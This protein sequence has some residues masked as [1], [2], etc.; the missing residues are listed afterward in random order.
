MT[1]ATRRRTSTPKTL[2]RT[3]RNQPLIIVDGIPI[4]NSAASNSGYGGGS[5]GGYDV[6]NAAADINAEN[7]ASYRSEPA[8]DHCR[9]HSHRQF[10]G[11]EQ[12]LRWRLAR[13]L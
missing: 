1:S 9:R 12:R 13:R 6:G 8:V 4:D 3:D 2:R 10:R 5:L 11:L 7:V